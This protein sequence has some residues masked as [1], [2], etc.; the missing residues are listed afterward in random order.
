MPTSVDIKNLK[1]NKLTEAQYDTAVQGGVIGAN[2]LS[3]ITDLSDTIQVSTMPTASASNEGQI[4]QFVGTT[5]ASYTNG[6]FYKCVSD[7]LNPATYSWE[8]VEVQAS[9]GGLPSQTGNAGKFLTTNGTDASWGTK[10][11]GPY[12]NIIGTSGYTSIFIA[13]DSTDK[14][15][16]SIGYT[17]STQRGSIIFKDGWDN[18]KNGLYF[19]RDAIYPRITGSELGSSTSY[20]NKTY[21]KNLNNGADIAVPTAGG[22]IALQIATLPTAAASLEGQIYQYI[23][24][25]DSTY[26]HG[27]IYECVSDNDPTNPTY[28]WSAINVQAGGGSGGSVP[29]LTWYSVSTAGNT[30]TI[31]DTSSAQL[32]KV[33]KNG[34]L[35]QPTDD[36]TISGT[37]LTTVG[38]LVVGDK[39]T[40]EVF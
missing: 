14:S 7:G 35:L 23:G 9:S 26:T 11:T 37:T 3:V 15:I 2:E 20:W 5:T 6:Y 12:E 29:T 8:A 30:L 21:T 24:A 4:V 40:T 31:A 36:Y 33:Y 17:N 18:L 39:I 22:T 25:T 27:Y 1:I 34:L 38:A 32:V 16:F 10:I 13:T 19:T 28:S